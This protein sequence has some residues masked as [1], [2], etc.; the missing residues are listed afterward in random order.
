MTWISDLSSEKTFGKSLKQR[1]NSVDPDRL[2]GSRLLKR[3]EFSSLSINL[4]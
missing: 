2:F 4:L 1:L 3:Y